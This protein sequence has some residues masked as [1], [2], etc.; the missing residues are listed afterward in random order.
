MK[1]RTRPRDL[2]DVINFFRRP[3][4]GDIAENVRAVLIQKCVYKNITFP[5]LNDLDEH[6]DACAT[7]WQDQL[8]HQ[9]QA[10]PPFDSF[11]NELPA[12]F[13]WLEHPEQVTAVLSDISSGAGEESGSIYARH[14]AFSSTLD[15]IR[16]AAVNR[17]CVE[18]VYRKEN[19]QQSTYLIEPYSLRATAEGN[20]V[21][22][23][24]KLP[25]A[26][27]RS[28][29]TDRIIS[30]AITQRTFTP[31]YSIDFI[32]EGPVRLSA[33]QTT[34]RKPDHIRTG[35]QNTSSQNSAVD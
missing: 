31:R 27:T 22:Y 30:V 33:R 28:F 6:K 1:E 7:G 24:V 17:M 26:E 32:P 3:E 34:S 14:T 10:L 16:F 11:W 18:M 20:M 8:A 35:R 19:G 23:A 4:S 29:R 12:F 25:T 15:R 5:S 2:Y 13:D 21:M 9:L